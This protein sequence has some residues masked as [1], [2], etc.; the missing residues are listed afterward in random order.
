MAGVHFCGRLHWGLPVRVHADIPKIVVFVGWEANGN[1]S[2]RG[3]GFLGGVSRAGYDFN[4]LVTADHI[5]DLIPGEEFDVRLNLRGGGCKCVR[6]KKAHKFSLK[7]KNDTAVFGLTF[8]LN[9]FDYKVIELDRK[10]LAEAK[11]KFDWD[12]GDE[13]AIVGL[14]GSHFGQSKN[15]PIIRIGH[16]AL[17]PGEPVV[18]PR[19]DVSAYLIE[20]KSIYGLSG[21]PVFVN[22]PFWAMQDGQP[23]YLRGP[24][25]IPLGMV[26]AFHSTE[27]AD[28]QVSVPD[29]AGDPTY[30]AP[31]RM[32]RNTGLTTVIP[33]EAILD[34]VEGDQM[35][36]A[37][38]RAYSRPS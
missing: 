32:D 29:L 28:D 8:D 20:G 33:I 4:V 5:L 18:S 26:L 25:L 27:S 17:M 21:S 37:L 24:L 35:L 16:I 15:V 6:F 34:I 22:A 12:I 10:A 36:K 30:P 2:P 13:V 14:Y 19:G 7:K 3:T 31:P 23:A 1:F 11:S 9:L 38:D